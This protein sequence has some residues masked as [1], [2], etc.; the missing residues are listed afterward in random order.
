MRG[1]E[2]K[3][4]RFG[5]VLNR[6]GFKFKMVVEMTYEVDPQDLRWWLTLQ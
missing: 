5:M 4:G 2:K 1:T 6:V 3:G